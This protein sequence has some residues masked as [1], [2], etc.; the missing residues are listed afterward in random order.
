MLNR[1]LSFSGRYFEE[2]MT[3]TFGGVR[4]FVI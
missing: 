3:G 2:E 4:V 1:V